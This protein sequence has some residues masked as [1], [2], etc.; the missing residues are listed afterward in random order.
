MMNYPE[1]T[2]IF[3]ATGGD[4]Q[5]IEE[6]LTHYDAYLSKKCLRILYDESGRIYLVVDEALKGLLTSELIY[7]MLNFE[8]S[9]K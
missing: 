7:A 4:V 8:M 3:A 1:F 5:A 6:I 9:I 2:L